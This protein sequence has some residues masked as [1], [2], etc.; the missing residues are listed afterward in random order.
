MGVGNLIYSIFSSQPLV[1]LGPTGPT[2]ILE[3][4]VFH[5]CGTEGIPFLEF[6]FWIG[7][8]T[9]IFM[10]VLVAFNSSVVTRLFTRFTE[11]IFTVLIGFFFIYLAFDWLWNIHLNYPYNK[12]ILF[13]TRIRECVCYQFSS[14]ESMN[15]PDLTGA[16]NLGS[17][18]E[19]SGQNCSRELLRRY[20]GEGCPSGLVQYHDVFL[21]SVILFFGTFLLCV[22]IKKIRKSNVLKSYVSSLAAA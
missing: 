22:Y 3:N 1:I 8:W 13:P 18:W 7:M 6:R 12:W 11:E 2:I 21:M 19:D 16:V 10:V 9:A 20:E 15:A 4:V 14:L 17:F 5:F